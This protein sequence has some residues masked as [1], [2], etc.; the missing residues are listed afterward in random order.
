MNLKKLQEIAEEKKLPQYR[1]KQII[2]AVYHEGVG[3]FLEMTTLPKDLRE[4]LEKEVQIFSFAVEKIIAAKNRQTIKAIL[5]LSTGE[6]SETVFIQTKPGMWSACISSQAGCAMNCAFCATGQNGF[7]RNL[8]AEEISDQVLFWKRYKTQQNITGTFSNVVYM[9]MGEPFANWKNVKESLRILLDPALLAFGARGISISTSGMP[10]GI[11]N[12]AKEFPQINLALSLHFA[13]DEK[14][15]KYMPVNKYA[16][17][18]ALRGALK[19]YFSLIKRK[20]FIEYLMLDGVN[21]TKEDAQDLAEYITSVGNAYLLYVN[22]IPYNTTAS[23]FTAS[24]TDTMRAFRNS[25]FRRGISVTVRKS[26]G[27][28]IDG[29]CGQLAGSSV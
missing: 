14:R 5:K 18:A 22:L 10:E 24:F 17:L 1:A 3:S 15:T 26:M 9:G 11:V 13:T 29:A 8:T 6:I 20:V 16:N 28:D 27:A 2:R 21:D 19:T 25:L 7:K 12:L 23:S 4:A